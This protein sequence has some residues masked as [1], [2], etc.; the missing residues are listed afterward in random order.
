MAIARLTADFYALC[1]RG[2]GILSVLLSLVKFAKVVIKP[3]VRRF[4]F[5]QAEVKNQC[6]RVV[7]R[8]LMFFG[9]GKKQE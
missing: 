1:V 9:K 6:L 3:N 2:N 5:L 4:G 7:A 8:A